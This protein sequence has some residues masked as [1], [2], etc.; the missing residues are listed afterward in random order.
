[1]VTGSA[2][3]EMVKITNITICSPKQVR[4]LSPYS[5]FLYGV[6]HLCV[7][8]GA[9]SRLDP[10]GAF[11]EQASEMLPLE[12]LGEIDELANL[13]TYIVSDYA[14]WLTGEVSFKN[15]TK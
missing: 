12:R 2:S 4:E 10:T 3:R 7:L 11:K 8:Q 1:M 5:R 15:K 13:A 6:F 9:F 14:N